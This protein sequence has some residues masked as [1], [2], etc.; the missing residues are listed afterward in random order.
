MKISTLSIAA[1]LLLCVFMLLS[2]VSAD[3]SAMKMHEGHHHHGH[4]GA[5]SGSNAAVEETPVEQALEDLP[6]RP[7]G[8]EDTLM[9]VLCTEMVKHGFPAEACARD[10]DECSAANGWWCGDARLAVQVPG[11]VA[12]LVTGGM[13]WPGDFYHYRHNSMITDHFLYRFQCSPCMPALGA[14][15]NAYFGL[16]VGGLAFSA[17]LFCCLAMLVFVRC[18]CMSRTR[19]ESDDDETL[20]DVEHL[21]QH[22]GSVQYKTGKLAMVEM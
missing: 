1:A 21:L 7:T 6:L 18:C 17:T 3:E 12:G 8:E 19:D 11:V 4:H 22:P 15:C 14:H 16:V 20:L 5:S 13:C 10:C 2:V 9:H